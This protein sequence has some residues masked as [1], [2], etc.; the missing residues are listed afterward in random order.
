MLLFN[1]RKSK[2]PAA[3]ILYGHIGVMKFLKTRF[4]GITY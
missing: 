4:Y 3:I 2:E 1:V